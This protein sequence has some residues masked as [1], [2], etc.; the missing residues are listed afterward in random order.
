MYV[1]PFLYAFFTQNPHCANVCL[2]KPS[3]LFLLYMKCFYGTATA[4]NENNL[5]TGV[6]SIL[7][8]ELQL[9]DG[10]LSLSGFAQHSVDLLNQGFTVL[11]S[12]AGRCEHP[13]LFSTP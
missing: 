1:T 5:V 3:L 4:V 2:S 9:K 12:V 13:G 6:V 8:K 10:T 7:E 11:E